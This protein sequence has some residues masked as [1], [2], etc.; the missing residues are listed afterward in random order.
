MDFFEF[1]GDLVLSKLFWLI[2][3]TLAS[4]YYYLTL[5]HDFFKVRGVKYAKPLPLFGSI[6]PTIFQRKT[7]VDGINDLYLAYPNEK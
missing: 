3:L 6:F 4:L 2:I 5:Q 7:V 1:F